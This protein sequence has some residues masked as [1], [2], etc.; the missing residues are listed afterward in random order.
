MTNSMPIIPL[1]AQL[2]SMYS[3]FCRKVCSRHEISPAEFDIID[4]LASGR[5][6]TSA[7]IARVR[8][9]KKANV[10]TAVDRLICRGLVEKSADQRDKR[11]IH[12]KLTASACELVS[13][14]K[15]AQEEFLESLKNI[16]TEVELKT[17]A[18]LFDKLVSFGGY[19][20]VMA[21]GQI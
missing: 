3:G 9:I 20:E 12:L 15:K 16:F 10:S 5:Y 4:V 1:S 6:D 14:V 11:L 21:N 13:D 8:F 7:Q 18:E 19:G 17:L 2:K